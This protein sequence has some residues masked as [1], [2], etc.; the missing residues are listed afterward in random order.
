MLQAYRHLNASD[1]G[2]MWFLVHFVCYTHCVCVLF[3]HVFM[4]CGPLQHEME[5]TKPV[6]PGCRALLVV[7]HLGISILTV[8]TICR[9][10]GGLPS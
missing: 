3:V 2:A 5:S 1:K 9:G 4:A 8:G 7:G 6:L 10:S